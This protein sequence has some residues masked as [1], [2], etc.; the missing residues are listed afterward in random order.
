MAKKQNINS[1][2]KALQ[3]MIFS[4]NYGLSRD[5]VDKNSDLVI[6]SNKA[7]TDTL[8]GFGVNTINHTNNSMQELTSLVSQSIRFKGSN[9][10]GVNLKTGFFKNDDDADMLT[11]IKQITPLGNMDASEHEVINMFASMHQSFLNVTEE[12]RGVVELIPEVGRAIKNIVRDILSV[13]ELSGRALNKLYEDDSIADSDPTNKDKNNTYICNK[14]L[15]EEIVDKND[16]ETKFKRWT[17]ESAVCGVKPVAFIPYDYIL[18]QLSSL[19]DKKY[20]LNLDVN[21]FA[22]KIKSGE[23][24]KV[25]DTKEQEERFYNV[26]VE[27]S[28]AEMFDPD[29]LAAAHVTAE[30]KATESYDA[31]LTDDLVAAYARSCESMFEKNY[32]DLEA[33]YAKAKDDEIRIYQITGERSNEAVQQVELL[34]SMTKKYSDQKKAWEEKKV[35]ERKKDAKAGL[36]ELARFIDEHID[37]VKPGASSAMIANKIMNERDRYSSFYNLGEN[38]LMA[39][40]LQRKQKNLNQ[41]ND[42]TRDGTGANPDFVYDT[43]SELGK[44]CLIV[45][46]SPESVIPINING[47]YMGFYALE[48]ENEIGSMWKKKRRAGTFTDYVK[49]QGFG[50]DAAL[51]GGSAPMVA[52]GGAD[53][54]ENNL[55]SPLAMYN[56]SANAYMTGDAENDQRFDIMKIVTLRV[57][58]HRLRDPD[59]ADNKTFKDAVM[60]LLRNDCLT[61]KKVQFTFIPP[62]YM[63][64]M[65]YQVDD[66]GIPKSILDGTLLWA[67]MYISSMLSSAMIKMLKSADKEKYE[68]S[69]GLLKNAGYT[70]DELQRVLSTRN[71]YSSNMFGSLSSVIKNAGTYQRMIIPVFNDKKLY[72]VTQIENINNVSPDDDFTGKLLQ[73][74]LGKIYINSGMQGSFDSPQFAHEFAYQNIEYRSNIIEEQANYEKHYTKIIRTL[75]DHSALDTYNSKAETVDP[76]EKKEHSNGDIDLSKIKVEL[77]ISTMMSMSNISEVIDQAKNVANSFVEI[78]NLESGSPTATAVATLFKRKIIEKYANIVE[79]TELEKMLKEAE[80]QAPQFVNNQKKLAKIDAKL[81]SEDGDDDSGS[82]FGGGDM[83]GGGDDLG[84]PF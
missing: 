26:S 69:V 29:K 63:C 7:V 67:Y 64:Y 44:D 73:S 18:R 70:I 52:Y 58:S 4:S 82:D 30:A 43:E 25:C 49:N 78:Y 27:S 11:G 33:K 71:I 46:Y 24:C 32:S 41:T 40:G 45:P 2:I 16:L 19:N 5:F 47:E 9:R 53:P 6:K 72:D 68:V 37:V 3:D 60:A 22:S 23:S 51:L 56:Y 48:Y 81:Q 15:Q 21:K 42:G 1:D 55:Y 83:G 34:D 80:V 76:D 38:Y 8:L 17:Y 35:D 79:W 74:I 66:D 77:N 75:A 50:D 14:L 28:F 31:L 20:G 39:E 12:Y 59:L 62:E 84:G 65:T 10:T 57:L 36:R 13:S 61:R 54:L